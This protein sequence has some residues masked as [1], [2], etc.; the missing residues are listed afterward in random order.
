M[1]STVRFF[2]LFSF[3]ECGA[4]QINPQLPGTIVIHMLV[5]KSLI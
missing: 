4:V 1:G 3:S 5:K 2:F